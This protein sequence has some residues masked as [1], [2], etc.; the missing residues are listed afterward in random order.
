M[1]AIQLVFSGK[2]NV[3]W[4]E[5]HS[6]GT[7]KNRRTTTTHYRA[8][9]VYFHDLLVLYGKQPGQSDN[10]VHPAGRHTFQFSS[11]LPPTLPSSFEGAHGSVR[12]C[13]K[14]TI[15]K[16]W[17]FDHN[18]KIAFTVVSNLDLN[19][20]A[21]S[22]QPFQGSNS[23]TLCCLCCTS[24][25][26]SATLTLD[27]LG[28]VPGE[29][30]HVKGEV[31]NGSSRLMDKSYAEITQAVGFHSTR[32]TRWVNSTVIKMKKGEIRGGGSEI[33]N[34][35][36]QIPPIPPSRLIYCNI[37][38]IQYQ[39]RLV[40]DP[41]GPALDLVVPADILIGTIPLRSMFQS[42]SPPPSA[43]AGPA[44]PSGAWPPGYSGG[45]PPDPAA[46]QWPA[47]YSGGPP[48]PMAPPAYPDLPPPS[49]GES[50]FGKTNIREEDDNDYTKGQMDYAPVYPFYNVG[51]NASA[52]PPPAYPSGIQKD[53]AY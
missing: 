15:D 44:P 45:P 22:L 18:T 37:I 31:S 49:Y 29:S 30:I 28:F 2:A 27:R 3:H 36:L 40:V 5:R 50:V 19:Q 12:Y 9:E 21:M 42:F 46:G 13:V 39:L 1:R 4:T 48:P 17:K 24:G 16:P 35:I 10:P 8:E 53:P 7:G 43:I 38:D 6:H 25:P 33:W 14:G 47:G 20:D 41:S 11:T 51:N 32:K 26:I 23:K 52:P 34:D